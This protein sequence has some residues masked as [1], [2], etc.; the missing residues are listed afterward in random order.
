MSALAIALIHMRFVLTNDHNVEVEALAHTLAMPLVG[1]VGETNVASKLPA[2]DVPHVARRLGCGLGVSGG[3]SLRCLGAAV[4]H[5]VAVLDVAGRCG[6][7][8]RDGVGRDGRGL[9]RWAGRGCLSEGVS[10]RGSAT[11]RPAGG[12]EAVARC[13]LP[14]SWFASAQRGRVIEHQRIWSLY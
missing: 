13:V 3:D 5:G 10:L 8:V 12:F 11:V 6:L 14:R 7:A 2:D 9:R 1:Q 4:K